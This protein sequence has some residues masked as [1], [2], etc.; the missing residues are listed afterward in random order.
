MNHVVWVE[1]KSGH[2]AVRSNAPDLAGARARAR[3]VE[4]NDGTVLIAHKAVIHICRVNIPSRDRSIRIDSKSVG[5][6]EGTWDVTGVRRIERGEGAIP[7][8][9][10]TVTQ[11]AR[12]KVVSHDGSI[13]SKA[14]AKST[15]KGARARTRRVKGGNGLRRYWDGNCQGD[16]GGCRRNNLEFPFRE[17]EWFHTS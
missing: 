16:Q 8:P 1:E 10:E 5:T 3:K 6:L 2:R 12:V 11:I 13:R 4:L 14:A 17:I 7:I 9:Q 15:L